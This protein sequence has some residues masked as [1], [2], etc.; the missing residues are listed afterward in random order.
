[1]QMLKGKMPLFLIISLGL[2]LVWNSPTGAAE[3]AG[4]LVL[5]QGQVAVRPAGTNIWQKARVHQNL[6]AGDMVRTGSNSRAAILCLDESQ[7]KLNENTVMVLKSVAPSPRLRLGAF[8][9][10]ASGATTWIS[11]RK[12]SFSSWRPP[13]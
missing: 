9:P 11:L 3:L 8:S 10:G 13:P 12:S 1:M 7:I 4:R 6:V 5:I 2:A